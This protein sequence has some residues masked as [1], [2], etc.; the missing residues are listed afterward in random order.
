MSLVVSTVAL[1][2]VVAA[3]SNPP[4]HVRDLGG[5]LAAPIN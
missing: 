1:T 2:S 3:G 5:D 4:A